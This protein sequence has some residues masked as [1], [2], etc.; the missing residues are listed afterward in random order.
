[1]AAR[2]ID[3]VLS[4]S[5]QGVRAILSP[6]FGEEAAWPGCDFQRE[7]AKISRLRR[8]WARLDAYWTSIR[9]RRG[10]GRTNS[11]T[12]TAS[13]SFSWSSGPPWWRSSPRAGRK[14]AGARLA[15]AEQL[16]WTDDHLEAQTMIAGSRQDIVALLGERRPPAREPE[17]APIGGRARLPSGPAASLPGQP[18]GDGA[19]RPA[20]VASRPG[21]DRRRPVVQELRARGLVTW[22]G[23]TVAIDD[24]EGLT[25][26]AEFDA[27]YLQLERM[28]V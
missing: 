14:L 9:P 5:R 20:P 8:R 7:P 13:W 15:V 26:V 3:C 16:I 10:P 23:D 21:P 25:K 24:W 12:S 4:C 17:G 2:P 27:T 1:M 11:A 18:G 6:S 28:P 19:R 22:S